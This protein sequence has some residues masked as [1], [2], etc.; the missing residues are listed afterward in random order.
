MKELHGFELEPEVQEWLVSLSDGDFK[1]VDEVAGLLAEKGTELGGPWPDHLEGPVW[2]LRLRLRDVA[3][4]G[5]VLVYSEQD[6]CVA[7][8]LQKDQAT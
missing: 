1:R 2:E 7:H 8:G 3:A 4:L 5:N 6:D